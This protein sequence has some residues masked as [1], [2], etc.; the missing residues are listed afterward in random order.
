MSAK[1][2][3][4]VR[5]PKVDPTSQRNAIAR[6]AN[7]LSSLSSQLIKDL[8]HWTFKVP[9]RAR[10]EHW[11]A[12]ALKRNAKLE[13]KFTHRNVILQ[14]VEA[15]LR[16][17]DALRDHAARYPKETNPIIAESAHWPAA[18]AIHRALDA[19]RAFAAIKKQ[20]GSSLGYKT[21][22][23]TKRTIWQVLVERIIADIEKHLPDAEKFRAAGLP[24]LL[25]FTDSNGKLFQLSSDSWKTGNPAE[26]FVA[27]AY[28]CD[29]VFAPEAD[30]RKIR[31]AWLDLRQPA[32]QKGFAKLPQNIREAAEQGVQFLDQPVVSYLHR[33]V[34][35]FPLRDWTPLVERRDQTIR[36]LVER[37]P[38][39]GNLWV[40]HHRCVEKIQNAF[41]R[42]KGIDPDGFNR[43]RISRSRPR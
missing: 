14:L 40:A 6:C 24:W 22:K 31:E 42:Y 9:R 19:P 30:R 13:A 37:P 33:Y 41:L 38:A 18:I 29:L 4:P 11:S 43:P 32:W 10:T 25:D 27:I 15:G 23:L 5:T 20:L 8:P 21:D 17:A 35:R 36:A 16:I 34:M 3:R 26:W 7:E 28:Y 12:A 39:N 2:S 1:S